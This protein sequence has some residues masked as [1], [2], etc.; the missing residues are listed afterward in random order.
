MRSR[1]PTHATYG[2]PF[3]DLWNAASSYVSLGYGGVSPSMAQR[4]IRSAMAGEWVSSARD[5]V[6][7]GERNRTRVGAT[8]VG[9]ANVKAAYWLGV[10]ARADRDQSLA[11]TA[12]TFVS[13][14]SATSS[15]I[16]A[17]GQVF[18]RALDAIEGRT[19]RAARYVRA[20]L[21]SQATQTVSAQR[22][23]RE[24]GST[25]ARALQVAATMPTAIPGA[26]REAQEQ[27]KKREQMIML[28]AAGG[29]TLIGLV[30]LLTR[31]G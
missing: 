5:A 6:P 7:V 8:T 19:S 13:H 27:K 1:H 9:Q 30:L 20:G 28:A 18:R 15:N 25:A 23:Q 12:Q 14:G 3:E 22:I 26:V 29:V 17:I 21:A 31:R 4:Q 11:Q 2:N 10:L 24:T 16:G